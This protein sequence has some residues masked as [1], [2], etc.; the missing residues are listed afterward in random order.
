MKILC[1]AGPHKG[2]RIDFP[3]TW[4]RMSVVDPDQHDVWRDQTATTYKARI[5][6]H[7]NREALVALPVADQTDPVEALLSFVRGDA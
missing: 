2:E 4:R 6:A 1:V 3:D 7:R 5:I